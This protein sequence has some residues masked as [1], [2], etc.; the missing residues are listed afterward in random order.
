[1]QVPFDRANTGPTT[2]LRSAQDDKPFWVAQDDNIIIA[3]K[4][5]DRTQ[6]R[7]QS[8]RVLL[9]FVQGRRSLMVAST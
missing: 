5:R 1:M 4:F 7:N 9:S 8:Y 2:P 6:E 3:A